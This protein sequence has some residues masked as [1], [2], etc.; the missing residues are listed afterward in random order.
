MN[1]RIRA[2]EVRVIG[3][4][5]NQLGIMPLDQALKLAEAAGLDLV[6]VAPEAQ[7]PVCRILDYGKY[8]YTQ[9][10][11]EHGSRKRQAFVTVKEVKVGSRTDPH[12][13]VYKVRNI[14][15]F[16]E[17]GE[18]VRVSVLFRGREITHPELGREMLDG[19]FAQV[20][21]VAKL[22]AAPRMEGRS[23]AMLL[24]PKQTS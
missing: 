14:R 18:R 16:I 23:M 21:D 11:K 15:R 9:K 20:Q 5:G 22:D 19:V 10:K 13:L 7:P 2:R 1:H 6:E 8:R 3:P 17:R 12:D 24:T 4:E